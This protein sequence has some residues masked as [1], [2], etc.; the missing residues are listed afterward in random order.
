MRFSS[1][2]GE[3]RYDALVQ[4]AARTVVGLDFDGTLSPI[5]ADPTAAHIHPDARDVLVELAEEVAAI[6][7]I[8]GRPARQALD[9]GGLEEVGDALQAAGK[10]LYVF[11]QYGN[12]RWTSTRRRIVGA[13]PPRGLATFE[14]DLPRLLRR[15]D[16][17]EAFIED[18]GLAVAV[19]TRRLPDPD[20][21]FERLLP[22]MRELAERNGLVL[23]PGRAVIEVRSA[24][25][26]KGLV[27]QR[28]ATVLDADGFLF[29]GDD[30]GDVEAF[31]ALDE[32][33]TAGV[34]VLKVCSA[35]DEQS[36]LAEM[37]DVVVRGPEGV[38]ALLAR[39]T[40]DARADRLTS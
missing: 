22:P 17:A 25:S 21:A 35:S 4:A 37:S 24:G 15:A 27:V 7:V 29:A 33:A 32:L 19:H 31:E 38:L 30:L 39:L 2:D 28:L 36:A 9:L 14:R 40:A 10:E 12:E 3:K 26:H 6:A 5:V 1:S 34:D 23:E 20:G 16:A 11:G 18:K 8:T 13:R